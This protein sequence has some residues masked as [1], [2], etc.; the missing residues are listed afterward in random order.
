[1]KSMTGFG[2]REY[3]DD[4]IQISVTLKSYNNKYL[5][6]FATV[7]PAFSQ[8]EPEIREFL[9]ARI[10]RGRVECYIQIRELRETTDI[11]LDREAAASYVK[12]LR[13]LAEL[14]G[15]PGEVHLSHL[16]RMEGIFRQNKIRDIDRVRDTLLPLLGEAFAQYD[17]SRAA[18]GEK[19]RVDIEKQL[20][21]L[22]D[23]VGFIEGKADAMEAVFAET[24]R[25]R[26]REV[27]GDLVDQQRIFAETA[28]LLVK[29]TINEEIVRMKSHLGQ[30]RRAVACGEPVGKG[31]DF[32]CQEL[33]R[34][35]NTIG[36]KSVSLEVSQRVLQMKEA[37]ERIRE[38]ARNVE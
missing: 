33:S 28:V 10:A 14:S 12:I 21:I 19:T 9:N 17:G 2:Y 20:S 11:Q 36:S 35:I 25:D 16:L 13:E 24:L 4:R 15:L 23:A 34:E 6:I 3:Q 37:L 29:Y 38:Q 31:L 27:C 22:E 5:D 18:E 32:L 1:M 8:L 26:F 30:F 7:P